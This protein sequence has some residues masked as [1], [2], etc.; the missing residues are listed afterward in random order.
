MM[1]LIQ[2]LISYLF[3]LPSP[4]PAPLYALLAAFA[5]YWN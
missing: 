2:S 1:K 4:A 3:P 5:H